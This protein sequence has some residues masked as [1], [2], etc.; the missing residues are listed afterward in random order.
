MNAECVE[1]WDA[2]EG[3]YRLVWN[4]RLV[5]ERAMNTEEKKQHVDNL[6][7]MQEQREAARARAQECPDDIKQVMQ[8]EKSVKTKHDFG[9]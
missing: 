3:K 9:M 2:N 8:A 5:E 4:G 6:F 1:E 7:N